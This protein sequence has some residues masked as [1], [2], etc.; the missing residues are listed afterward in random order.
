MSSTNKIIYL[1]I[2]AILVLVTLGGLYFSSLFWM[3]TQEQ[4]HQLIDS[5]RA[6]YFLNRFLFNLI[7]VLVFVGVIMLLNK[8]MIKERQANSLARKILLINI[9]ILMTA[10][11]VMIYLSM[12]ID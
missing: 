5:S 12:R 8:L 1:S 6:S 3:G 4:H 11:A 9:L 2:N 7:L 10:S